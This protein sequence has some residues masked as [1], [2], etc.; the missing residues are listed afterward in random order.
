MLFS[1]PLGV[2]KMRCQLHTYFFAFCTNHIPICCTTN[3]INAQVC[4][5][6]KPT[7]LPRKLKNAPKKLPRAAGN[8]LKAFIKPFIFRWGYP[9]SSRASSSSKDTFNSKYICW[10][11]HRKAV[12]ILC[13]WNMIGIRSAK[14]LPSS[15]TFS[16]VNLILATCV[17]RSFCDGISSLTVFKC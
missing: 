10:D 14:Y 13:S 4:S 1:W 11:D 5:A 16:M 15:S 3:T 17:L 7:I 6:T 9:K 2:M 12:V 8:A